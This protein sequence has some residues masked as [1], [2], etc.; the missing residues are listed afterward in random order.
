MRKLVF[1]SYV[2]LLTGFAAAQEY[3]PYNTFNKEA[4]LQKF[5]EQGGKAEEISTDVYRLTNR[6]GESR[7]FYLG[8]KEN[9]IEN[10]E[11]ID[12][13]IINIWEIDTTKFS[14]MFTFW[15]Q[16]QVNNTIWT[17]LPVGDLNNNGHPEL[18]GF[19]DLRNNQILA[20][21]VKIF[22]RSDNGIYENIFTY[23]SSTFHVKGIADINRN[24]NNEIIIM[25]YEYEDSLLF[26]YPVYKSDTKHNLPTTFNFFFY[27]DRLQIN[28]MYFGDW[29]KNEITDCAFITSALW[30]LPLC[31]IAEYRDSINN[32]EELFRF[33]TIDGD[34]SGFAIGDFDQDGRTELIFSSVY[35]NV[36]VIENQ[37]K[38]EYSIVNQFPF[39]L[40]NSYMHATTNDIDGNGKPEFW[41]GGQD[42]SEGVTVLQCYEAD[43]D[44][45]Y[46]PVARLEL[47]YLVSLNNFYI[48]AVDIDDDGKEEIIISIG[49][50]ILIL[51]F[52]GSAHNHLYKLWFAKFGE[53]TQPDAQFYPAVIADLDG[54]ARKDLLIPMTRYTPGITYAFSY[55][56]RQGKPS[57]ITESVSGDI[58]LEFIQ[59]Y[60]NPFNSESTISFNITETSNVQIKI[61]NTLGKEIT[62][63]LEEQLSPGEYNIHW[64]A[65]DKYG[66]PLP[67]GVYFISL[68]SENDFKTTKTLFLK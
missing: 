19:T 13:T 27:I 7:T 63:L 54:D 42:F 6:V 4:E 33:E 32:F 41:I 56:L 31:I 30:E 12:T 67:S 65:R 24:G 52:V 61:Y 18:Y 14:G 23:D 58:P 37:S 40:T 20:G 53:A 21:P 44:N 22:E 51:K 59:S 62:T 46:R 43:G 48:Q 26:Y 1:I 36:F 5:V 64:E 35:G 55:I 68:Q 8:S 17:L 11:P 50:A 3:K 9:V 60:P 34:L 39:P 57:G 66:N 25:A 49:N 10:N 16:V 2:L 38:N 29:D 15:Q 28:D 45:R 47:R